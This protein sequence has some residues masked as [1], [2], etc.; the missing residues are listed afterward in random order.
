MCI[1]DSLFF[2]T[3]KNEEIILQ[4]LTVTKPSQTEM[5]T[6]EPTV[7]FAGAADPDQDLFFD[8][9]K[10]ETND[11]GYFSICLLYISRCV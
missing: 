1:R 8:G 9:E 11:S 5:T 2:E 6:Y 7:T 3:G 10:I 4:E